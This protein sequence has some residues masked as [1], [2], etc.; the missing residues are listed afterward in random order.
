M[1]IRTVLGVFLLAVCKTAL[2]SETAGLVRIEIP[3]NFQLK[4]S[5]S[6]D[7]MHQDSYVTGVHGSE[8]STLLQISIFDYGDELKDVP[9]EKLGEKAAEYVLEF[10]GSIEKSHAHFHASPPTH[11]ALG[12]RPGARVEWTG[13]PTGD[14]WKGTV[15]ETQ[16]MS[17]VLYC[18]IVGTKIVWFRT[19]WFSSSPAADR[20]NALRAIEA[21]RFGPVG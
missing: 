9:K 3:E 16:S 13:S 6:Q 2:P 20:S 14:E 19:Q 8:H 18:V 7:A 12:G 15:A 21:V 17:G 1:L 5:G 10:L 4:S 11:L